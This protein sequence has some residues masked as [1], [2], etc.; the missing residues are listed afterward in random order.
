[1]EALC[2]ELVPLIDGGELTR[3]GDYQLS[4]NTRQINRCVLRFGIFCI[5]LCVQGLNTAFAINIEKHLLSSVV[6]FL[7]RLG[8]QF[9]SLE[10]THNIPKVREVSDGLA[11]CILP[12][13]GRRLHCLCRRIPGAF[14]RLLCDG[15]LQSLLQHLCSERIVSSL[16]AKVI[17]A[18]AAEVAI[19]HREHVFRFL[20]VGNDHIHPRHWHAL[21]DFSE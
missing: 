9:G 21:M 3:G 6:G 5:I 2:E 8:V 17:S 12:L 18:I 4:R 14:G 15:G 11:L 10:I 7:P 1:M 19:H 20:C 13:V 16:L